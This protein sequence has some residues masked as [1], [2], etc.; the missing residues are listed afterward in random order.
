MI[1]AQAAGAFSFTSY[2]IV[3]FS[4]IEPIG[5]NKGISIFFDPSGIFY[6][7]QKSYK[8]TFEVNITCGDGIENEFISVTV[9]ANFKFE[10]KVTEDTI[11]SYFYVNS[12]AIVFPYFRSFVT[13]LTALAN[14]KPLILPTLNLTHLEKELK[15]KTVVVD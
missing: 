5:D 1:E 3:K 8:L 12:I 13:T 7:S 2:K 14:I 9:E 6:K 11:P 10:D 4:L 15:E